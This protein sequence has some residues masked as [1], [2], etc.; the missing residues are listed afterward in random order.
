MK[1]IGPGFGMHL[2]ALV[3]RLAKN[4]GVGIQQADT[5]LLFDTDLGDGG[6]GRLDL[7]HQFLQLPAQ[8]P[9]LPVDQELSHPLDAF[10]NPFGLKGL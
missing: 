8:G 10:M 1:L 3:F 4:D 6:S 9:L 2:N 7:L 5:S